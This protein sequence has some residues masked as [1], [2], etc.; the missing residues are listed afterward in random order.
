VTGSPVLAKVT[1]DGCPQAQD[2]QG[3]DPQSSRLEL[4]FGS[5][6]AQRLSPVRHFE[7]APRGLSELW[8]VQEPRRGRGQLS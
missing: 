8:M 4:A 2:Q 3:E 6:G 1:N 7:V 5:T